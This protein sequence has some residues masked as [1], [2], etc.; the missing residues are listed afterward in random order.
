MTP[1]EAALRGR[2]GGLVRDGRHGSQELGRRGQAGLRARFLADVQRDHPDLHPAEQ[3][4]RA[5]QLWRAH[6]AKARYKG[7]AER[8]RAKARAAEANGHA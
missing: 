6:L 2:I 4:R 7:H 5:E 3:A 1:E 8:R